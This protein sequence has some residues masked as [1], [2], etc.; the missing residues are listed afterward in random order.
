MG[1]NTISHNSTV[2]RISKNTNESVLN[3]AFGFTFYV[4]IIC[5]TSSI[6]YFA[7]MKLTSFQFKIIHKVWKSTIKLF[8]IQIERSY[9]PKLGLR[10]YILYISV[11]SLI[12][13]YSALVWWITLSQKCCIKPLRDENYINTGFEDYHLYPANTHSSKV[14]SNDEL[15]ILSH[16]RQTRR[17]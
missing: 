9:S 13:T 2:C 17:H 6:S 4:E 12:P 11:I 3:Y 14:W 8:G 10:P 7:I 15:M 5:W 1:P 16:W